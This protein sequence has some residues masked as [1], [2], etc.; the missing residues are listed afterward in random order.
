MLQTK[1]AP[2][3]RKTIVVTRGSTNVRELYEVPAGNS[4]SMDVIRVSYSYSTERVNGDTFQEREDVELSF[5]Y[6]E[7]K[8]N[9][10]IAFQANNRDYTNV[11]PSYQNQENVPV[12][13]LEELVDTM[14]LEV[15][16]LL[17]TLPRKK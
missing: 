5:A 8:T 1:K 2:V 14:P 11:Y 10:V 3:D 7:G 13:V 9:K 15:R 12:D 16:R 4:K 6:P 17:P